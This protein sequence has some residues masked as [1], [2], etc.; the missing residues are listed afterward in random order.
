MNNCRYKYQ[1]KVIECNENI[2]LC[3][4]E[5]MMF[6]LVN[7]FADIWMSSLMTQW[8][9]AKMVTEEVYVHYA[10]IWPIYGTHECMTYHYGSL[11]PTLS[12]NFSI[13][14]TFM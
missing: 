1:A 7:T 4:K 8:I 11:G 9:I 6:S 10:V 13:H 3:L 14:E 12:G 5:E 2:F